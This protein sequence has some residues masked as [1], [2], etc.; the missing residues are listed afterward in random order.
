ML[1]SIGDQFLNNPNKEEKKMAKD[2]DEFDDLDLEEDD[3]ELEDLE[4]EEDEEEEE[5]KED[6]EEEDDEE[7]EEE[8]DEEDEDSEEEEDDEEEEEEE[9]GDDE[10]E[11]DEEEE[12]EEEDEDEEDEE[13]ELP[14]ETA[15]F[16]GKK[17]KPKKTGKGGG[18]G[19]RVNRL[20][21]K[22]EQTVVPISF[23]PFLS[24][25]EDFGY[26]HH[27]KS[28]TGI[29]LGGKDGPL[30][31]SIAKQAT[32]NQILLWLN[33][34]VIDDENY[35]R[36]KKKSHRKMCD[37]WE[38]PSK[39]VKVVVSKDAIDDGLAIVEEYVAWYKKNVGGTKKKAAPKKK[40][41]EEEEAP[42]KKKKS[43]KK[44]PKEEVVE[45]KA[46]KKKSGK[47]KKGGKKKKK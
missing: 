28:I 16:P 1:C 15:R 44:A 4:E 24:G 26:V 17:I 7:E 39:T 41:E 23:K 30:F 25:V 19:P 13:E 3:D 35:F 40:V 46:S 32:E 18:G 37:F 10:E 21:I 12:E 6:E 31:C 20:V 14:P 2:K 42:K 11:E 29:N 43:K 36:P 38:K 27:K 9:E 47:K 5:E 8:E 33:K 34:S 22:G 45:K